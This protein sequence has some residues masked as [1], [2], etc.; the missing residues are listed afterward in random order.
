MPARPRERLCLFGSGSA[1]LGL[2]QNEWQ[3]GHEFFSNFVKLAKMARAYHLR[4]VSGGQ[5]GVYRAALRVAVNLGLP[6]GGWIPRG[7]WAE[8]FRN[9]H[10]PL[11]EYRHLR[12]TETS[13]PAERTRLNVRDSDATLILIPGS[14][15]RL[16]PGTNLTEVT[17]REINKPLLVAQVD[18]A[19]SGDEIKSWLHK[20]DDVTSL[21][22]AGPRESQVPGIYV[23]SCHLL[24]AVL[25]SFPPERVRK[26]TEAAAE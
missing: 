22:V 5:T 20:Y 12:E 9:P 26:M 17:A 11:D 16:S 24:E 2:D 15:P 3:T 19:E 4:I 13:D 10:G 25:R 8:D 21:N 18:K 6:Y 14:N 7:R 1:G 23:L